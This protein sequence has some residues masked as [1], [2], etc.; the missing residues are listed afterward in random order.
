MILIVETCSVH[1]MQK[2][3][4]NSP[5]LHIFIYFFKRGPDLEAGGAL[6]NGQLLFLLLATPMACRPGIKPMPQK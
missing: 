4:Y 5:F 1:M 6:E 3:V 2:F